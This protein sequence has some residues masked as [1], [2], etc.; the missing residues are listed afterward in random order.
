MLLFVWLYICGDHTDTSYTVIRASTDTGL[1][2]GP[3]THAMPYKG[4]LCPS[5]S[6][7]RQPNEILLVSPCEG[8]ETEAQGEHRLARAEPGLKPRQGH[9]STPV[10]TEPREGL[11]QV[12]V[13]L[14]LLVSSFPKCCGLAV[15]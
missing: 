9:A 15:T 7:L 4:L 13:T 1:I 8:E 14:F 12:A 11:G 3:D 2:P 10:P 6:H 5:C